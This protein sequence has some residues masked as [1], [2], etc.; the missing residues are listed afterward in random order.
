M[1]EGEGDDLPGIGRIGQRL[2]IAGHA[3]VEADLADRRRRG[4]MGAE[5]AAPEHRAVGQHQRGGGARRARRRWPRHRRAAARRPP[6]RSASARPVAAITAAQWRDGIDPAWRH[7]RTA[8][9]PTPV[10]RAAASAPPSRSM[11]DS[12]LV[13]MAATLWEEI[14]HATRDSQFWEIFSGDAH[15]RGTFAYYR[16]T[17]S[18]RR[19]AMSLRDQF[20][21]QL[22]ASMKAGDAPR[23]STLRMILAKLKDIDIAARPKGIDKVPDEEI[24]RDAAR[25]GEVPPRVG[26]A[27]PAGQPAG[28]GRQGGGR[29]R[30]DRELPAAA[31]G[32]G[33]D[34]SRRSTDAIAE[35]GAASIKDMGKVMAALRAKHAAD[36]R[37]GQ[38]RPD[39]E[40]AAVVT[41]A[42]D[43]PP[44]A[45]GGGGVLAPFAQAPSP[46]PPAAEGRLCADG[47][48]PAFLDELRA[49][50]PLAA[51]IGRRV[52]LARSGR[53]MEGLLPVP[54]REDPELLRLRRRLP[55]LRLRRAWRR[56]QL[57]HAEP[58]RRLHG[59]GRATGRRGRAGGAEAHRRRRPRPNAGGTTWP[60]VLEAAQA[61][62]QRRLFLPE[63][64]HALDYLL[65][66]RPD[67]GDH[68]PLRPR[69]VRRGPRR[70]GGGPGAATASTQ[71][72]L[73][74][75]G[76]MRRDDETGRVFDLFF[77][78][79][80]FPIRDRR[81]RIISF[82]GRI[83]GRRPAEIRQRAG[84][85]AVLQAPQPLRARS[86]ARGGAR[87]RARWWWSRATWT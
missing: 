80:M 54:R 66:P 70:A 27:V 59:G 57:R 68:P 7:L 74:E 61:S 76:L 55:L 5:A 3:G 46:T 20:T 25:H 83:L 85:G 87:R 35:T 19:D 82:G 11:M 24:A 73:V 84:D 21:D 63:G 48:V 23:T 17:I 26:G 72:Q 39:G 13:V 52:R 44:R 2:L 32:R 10:S 16:G 8:S 77:N 41:H 34:G 50:T 47:P 30:G 29:D 37:H 71:D 6:C 40:G 69:L 42:P 33:G 22:K 58:G 78:R 31:D 38:G 18:S 86:G 4:G 45:R 60:S 65:R 67:R 49:R 36:A 51:V 14:S 53:Q 15:S 43:P 12:T 81:G 75:A 64:R 62:Y 28:S 56:H 79:V 1:R 9:V